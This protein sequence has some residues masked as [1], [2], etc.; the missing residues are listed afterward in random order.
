MYPT[1][2]LWFVSVSTYFLIIS[3]ASTLGALW[4]L[5]RAE[6][7]DLS[8]LMAI[9]FTLVA[10]IAGFAGARLLHVFY[11]DPEYYHVNPLRILQIWNGGFVFLGGVIGAVFGTYLFCWI[12]NLPFLFLAD[13]AVI[14]LSFAYSVGRIAC[15]MN[16]CCY[17]SHCDLPWAVLMNGEHRH[18]SQLY[19]SFWEL[20][21]LTTLLRMERHLTTPGK[22]T[23][24][25][26][27]LHGAGRILMEQYRADPR[28]DMIAG[29]SLASWLSCGL[30][31][32]G[33]ALL[34]PRNVE[35]GARN[36]TQL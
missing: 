7:K 19:A 28:G 33:V 12:R 25:W 4:F 23:G 27:L 32:C 6:S 29:Q 3:M 5:R 34:W 24:F 9:D 14:P 26:L 31:G 13:L 21:V 16:G 17:G 36:A 10:L 11:E 30:I 15:F 8:R 35:S 1:L 20:G 22:L 18:P 2:N